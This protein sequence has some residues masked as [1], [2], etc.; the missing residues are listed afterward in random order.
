MG[1]QRTQSQIFPS[2]FHVFLSDPKERRKSIE[3]NHLEGI[4]TPQEAMLRYIGMELKGLKQRVDVYNKSLESFLSQLT[5]LCRAS[6][7]SSSHKETTR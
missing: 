2:I 4:T 3:H 5:D 6:M 1:N 7:S